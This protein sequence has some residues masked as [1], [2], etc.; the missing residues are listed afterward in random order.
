MHF[1][2]IPCGVVGMILLASSFQASAAVNAPFPT[3]SLQT[4][5]AP[6]HASTLQTTIAQVNTLQRQGYYRR[7]KQLLEQA[8]TQLANQPDSYDKLLS[9]LHL[10]NVLR[11]MGDRQTSQTVLEQALAIAQRLPHQS[12][13]MALASFHLANTL[14]AQQ[15]RSDAL[16]LYR[17]ASRGDSPVRLPALLRSLRLVLEQ[18]QWDTGQ[19]YLAQIQAELPQA[20]QSSLGIYARLELADILHAWQSSAWV[21]AITAQRAPTDQAPSLVHLLATAIQKARSAHDLR[22]ESIGLGRLSGLYEAQGQWHHA[23]QLTEKALELAEQLNAPDLI[24][25]WQWQMGRIRRTQNDRREAIGYYRSAIQSLQTIRQDL[26]AIDTEVQFSFRDQ[27]EPVYRELVELL[28]DAAEQDKAKGLGSSNR[29]DWAQEEDFLHEAQQVIESLQ[30]AELTDYF[31]EACLD[32]KATTV[33][34]V[35]P[36]AAIIYPIILS[37]RLTVIVSIPGQPLQHYSTVL[38]QAHI[39]ATLDRFRQSMR[40]TSFRQERLTVA[41]NLHQWLI[42]PALRHL[43]QHNIKTLIFVPDGALRNVPMAALHDGKQYLIE[44]FGIGVTPTLKVLAAPPSPSDRGQVLAAGLSQGAQNYT[45][46]PGVQAELEQIQRIT[47]SQILL[48]QSFT[49]QQIQTLLETQPISILHL[50]SHGQFSSRSEDTYLLAVDGPLRLEDLDRSLR[51]R[52]LKNLRPLELL[53]LSACETAQGDRRAVLGLAG[54]AVRSG[55]RSTL[56]SL[57]TV[58]D[59]STAQ[60]ME[61]FYR[62]LQQA[63][64][65]RAEAVRQAQLALLKQDLYNHPYYWAAFTLVGNWQ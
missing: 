65:S 57:W 63:H 17:T 28:I 25:Q 62:A 30:L 16:T 3:Q 48:D 31:R 38:P 27:V 50:A 42:Q 29:V 49:K 53:V 26:A 41:K 55:A 39:E 61:H 33:D 1:R 23:Q 44:Q 22:A 9:L 13:A 35:D 19:T 36:Q 10:G 34:S 58:N 45:P 37:N 6:P 18:Q 20:D 14:A 4:V 8:Q 46:L 15:K 7:A 59:R 11:V 40:S 56:A 12:Q 21:P 24:Y 5:P 51:K 32:F 2:L 43:N 54:I 47:R 64:L 60:F 52:E